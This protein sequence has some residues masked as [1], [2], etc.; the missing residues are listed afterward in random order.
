MMEFQFS[1]L[2]KQC[3]R[4]KIGDRVPSDI[5]FLDVTG[6]C[7]SPECQE[8]ADKYACSLQGRP[9]G[10]GALFRAK[11]RVNFNVIVGDI[12]D[13]IIIINY[14][15]MYLETVKEEW[16]SCWIPRKP[17]DPLFQ[18]WNEQKAAAYK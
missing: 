1:A 2:E 15:D 12:Y 6:C 10:F 18:L 17:V 13:V 16:E 7:R 3:K 4:Y 5:E 11:L 14:T 8:R 9:S